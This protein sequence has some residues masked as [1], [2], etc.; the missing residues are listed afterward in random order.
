M[1]YSVRSTTAGTAFSKPAISGFSARGE[2]RELLS[3]M[4]QGQSS[5]GSF[6]IN[7]QSLERQISTYSVN[8]E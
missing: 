6:D 3:C 4:N 7:V 5:T 2:H 8:L 1:E